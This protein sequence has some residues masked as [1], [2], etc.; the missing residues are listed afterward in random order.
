M[1]ESWSAPTDA[2]PASPATAE[3]QQLLTAPA[4]DEFI[5]VVAGTISPAQF[6][7]LRPHWTDPGHGPDTPAA[8]HELKLVPVRS[9]SALGSSE[10]MTTDTRTPNGIHPPQAG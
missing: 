3:M 6:L 9:P 10:R 7:Q 2:T 4:M 1:H 8:G 5:G